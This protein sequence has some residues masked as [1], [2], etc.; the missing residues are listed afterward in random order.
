M[1]DA[2][3]VIDRPESFETMPGIK[4]QHIDLRAE[5]DD[6]VAASGR[7]CHQTLEQQATDP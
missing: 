4:G 6:Q 7:N 3:I 1:R 2:G 5:F